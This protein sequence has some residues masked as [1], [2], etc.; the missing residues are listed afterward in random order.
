MDNIEKDLKEQMNC[1]QITAD[2]V[3]EVMELA[4]NHGVSVQENED[5]VLIVKSVH[6]YGDQGNYHRMVK[7]AAALHEAV[8]QRCQL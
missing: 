4:E 7:E 1:L 5:L 3:R 6:F 8:I 2:L